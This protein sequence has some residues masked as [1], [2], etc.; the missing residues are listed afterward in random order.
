MI[1][2]CRNTI[3]IPADWPVQPTTIEA[4]QD[5]ATC[6]VC[7]LTWD[8]AIV[9]SMTPAPSARCPFEQFHT[10]EDPPMHTSDIHKLINDLSAFAMLIDEDVYREA[11]DTGLTNDRPDP[12]IDPR[13]ALVWDMVEIGHALNSISDWPTIEDPTRYGTGYASTHRVNMSDVVGIGGGDEVGYKAELW[14]TDGD[15]YTLHTFEH[16]NN[17]LDYVANVKRILRGWINR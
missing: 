9:T 13:G 5:P 15:T 4:A 16:S 8:D 7:G 11:L 3:P 1:Y 17:A 6:G 2:V 12:A 10:Q 14:T